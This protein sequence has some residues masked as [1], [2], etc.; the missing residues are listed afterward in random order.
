M[1]DDLENL[2]LKIDAPMATPEYLNFHLKTW[3]P[4]P[5]FPVVIDKSGAVIS[6][7]N[8]PH[9]DISVWGREPRILY[10]EKGRSDSQ[11]PPIDKVNADL[12]RRVTAWM[13]WG[14]RGARNA[15]TLFSKFHLIRPIF[16]FCSKHKISLHELNTN[17]HLFNKFII[18]TNVVRRVQF[19]PLL[20]VLHSQRDLIGITLI[21]TS[22]LRKLPAARSTKNESK[23]TAYIPPRIF[24]Y[25]AQRIR[26][27]LVDYQCHQ[28]MIEGLFDFCMEAYK[29]HN[30]ARQKAERLRKW[31]S[32]SP[33]VK[34]P[35][36]AQDFM[37]E[38][39]VGSFRDAAAKYGVEELLMRWCPSRKGTSVL[40]VTKFSHYLTMV[41]F[42]GMA[43]ILSF[44]PM[45]IGEGWELRSNALLKHRDP[46]FGDIFILRGQSI[47]SRNNEEIW[48]TSPETEI[49]IDV[50]ASVARLRAKMLTSCENDATTKKS[51]RL[52]S[53]A[54]EP[55][56][57]K[58]QKKNRGLGYGYP[59]YRDFTSRN[60]QFFDQSKLKTTKEDIDIA[61][62]ITPSLNNS[63][64]KIGK[65][66]PISWHQL[67]RSL[68]VNMLASGLVSEASLQFELKH[69]GRS[70]ALY[71]GQ[72]YSSM[73]IS[74]ESR[75]HYL[76]TLYESLGRQISKLFTDRFVSPHGSDRKSTILSVVG[77]Q[78]CKK[79][80]IA[81]KTGKISWRVTLLGGCTRRG[82][83]TYGG[84]DNI[85]RCAGGDGKAPCIDAIFDREREPQ[86][87]ELQ[88]TISARLNEAIE[89]SPYRE[90]L[91]AQRRAVESALY[92]IATR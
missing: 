21:G 47:K 67:R 91:I 24:Q 14:Y 35:A 1:K 48:V 23:Q 92:V 66:W 52:I 76:K 3:P 83:C 60:P 31:S 89:E 90:A 61:R 33:F 42:V 13:I 26:E 54:S 78:D 58:R 64:F 4:K 84:I 46:R 65:A 71:Y 82:P 73:K 59:S 10:F 32:S 41:N 17:P 72:G 70:M 34:R 69:T 8:H 36:Y 16:A 75:T 50:L 85:A 30:I 38:A 29:N 77:T 39:Y 80:E 19:R 49:A 74:K 81:A 57:R 55:W 20:E 15:S 62:L 51:I 40:K 5:N 86:L 18:E 27:F 45:R 88:E 79:L 44:S 6:L 56:T 25:H 87:R 12:L 63:R 22:G 37:K 2:F 11:L 43:Y 53:E 9:W 7:Y 68:S 28:E